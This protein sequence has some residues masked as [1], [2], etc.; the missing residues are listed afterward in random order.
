MSDT[1]KTN[2]GASCAAP[3]SAVPSE[4]GE[5][6]FCEEHVYVWMD[7]H[8]DLMACGPGGL[9]L[10]EEIAD[11]DQYVR[12]ELAELSQDVIEWRKVG[13][14]RDDEC[15]SPHHFSEQND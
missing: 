6:E 2:D 12:E 5:Y 14:C 7:S 15:C 9:E 11:Y 10:A 8:G 4:C 13:E 1:P 3:C